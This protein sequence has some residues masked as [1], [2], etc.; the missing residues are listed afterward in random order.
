MKS[1]DMC[2]SPPSVFMHLLE[3]VCV[4]PYVLLCSNFNHDFPHE[5]NTLVE[6]Q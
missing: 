1:I 5:N 2:K 4:L 6:S 3:Y